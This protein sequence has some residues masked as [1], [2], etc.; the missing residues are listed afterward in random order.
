M[1]SFSIS[2]LQLFHG[3]L[4]EGENTSYSRFVST[5]NHIEDLMANSD[6]TTGQGISNFLSKKKILL[7]TFSDVP[8]VLQYSI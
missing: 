4:T 5:T 2:H 3:A 7:I 6:G 8:Q 1:A